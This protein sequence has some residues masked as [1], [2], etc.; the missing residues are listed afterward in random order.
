MRRRP[1]RSACARLVAAVL[2]A[3][4]AT[5]AAVAIGA[6]PAPAT[7]LPLPAQ[8][9]PSAGHDPVVLVPGW[10]GWPESMNLLITVFR[11]AGYPTYVLNQNRGFLFEFLPVPSTATFVNGPR[12]AALVDQARAETGAE[13]VNLVGYS[14]G[15]LVARHYVK[16]MGGAAKVERYVG[17]GVPQRGVRPACGLPYDETGHLCPDSAF[18]R[19]LNGGDDSPDGITYANIWSDEDGAG[20]VAMD[21]PVCVRHI[22]GV[23]HLGEPFSLAVASEA[24]ARVRGLACPFADRF[25]GT[26]PDAQGP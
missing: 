15:G 4:A 19:A 12:L 14:Y 10:M 18:I 7:P 3:A 13:R 1:V 6:T 23:A 8:P 21:G 5:A 26:V 11:D 20:N 16:D 25:A 22:P 17:I 9:L 24:L 2:T